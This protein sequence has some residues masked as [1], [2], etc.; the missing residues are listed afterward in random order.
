M[1]WGEQQYFH[2]SSILLLLF[3]LRFCQTCWNTREEDCEISDGDTFSVGSMNEFEE[4]YS[5][6]Q[7]LD[8]L[9]NDSN[10]LSMSLCS[11]CSKNCNIGYADF[12]GLW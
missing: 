2:K 9:E 11:Q 12:N 4:F 10:R 6:N 3:F 7:N 5:P 8:I 1:S